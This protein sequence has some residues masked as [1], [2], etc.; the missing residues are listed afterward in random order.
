M[1]ELHRDL[2]VWL[3]Y[4]NADRPHSGKYCY[5]KTPLQTFRDTKGLALEKYHELMLYKEVSDS[6]QLADKKIV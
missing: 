5:G 4:Y 1:A 3:S 2:D 6:E